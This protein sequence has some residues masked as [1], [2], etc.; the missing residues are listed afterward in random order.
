MCT[1]N[2]T[3][4]VSFGIPTVFLITVYIGAGVAEALPELKV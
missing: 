4:A 2:D 3:V 1:S